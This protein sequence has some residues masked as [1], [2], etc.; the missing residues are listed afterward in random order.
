MFFFA[1]DADYFSVLT[2][3]AG[4]CRKTGFTSPRTTCVSC[5]TCDKETASTRVPRLGGF[6]IL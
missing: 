5:Q 4:V 2:A 3:T 1:Y 6:R